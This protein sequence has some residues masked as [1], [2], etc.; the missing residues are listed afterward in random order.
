MTKTLTVI[1][2]FSDNTNTKAV[3]KLDELKEL[4]A[5]K[6]QYG[7]FLNSHAMLRKVTDIVVPVKQSYYTLDEYLSLF[8]ITE[9]A[10]KPTKRVTRRK[11]K[12][13]KDNIVDK[14]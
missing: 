11:S 8:P 4:D 7:L 5:R 2:F 9:T 13:L 14:D 6:N 10:D 3:Y 1:L 12:L